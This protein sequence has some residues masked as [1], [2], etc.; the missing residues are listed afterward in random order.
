MPTLT[1]GCRRLSTRYL[2]GL[3]AQDVS[4][5][6]AEANN[7]TP[8]HCG[9]PWLCRC[10]SDTLPSSPLS[11]FLHNNIAMQS[12]RIRAKRSAL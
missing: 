8:A 10:T 3:C 7:S 9:G 2:F 6:N 12:A 11:R 1:S 5:S 4:G